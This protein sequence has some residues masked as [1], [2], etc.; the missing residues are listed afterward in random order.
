MPAAVDINVAHQIDSP[1]GPAPPTPLH[2]RAHNNA[3]SRETAR[4]AAHA[5]P[6]AS[7]MP[8]ETAKNRDA[9]WRERLGEVT[10]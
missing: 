7:D 10:K 4:V 5:G 3:Q 9:E 8:A 6:L 2:E 1:V